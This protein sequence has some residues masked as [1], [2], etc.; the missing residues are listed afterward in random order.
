MPGHGLS[1]DVSDF[2]H[3]S[4]KRLEQIEPLTGTASPVDCL[5]SSGC[6]LNVTK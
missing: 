4:L 1:V 2:F 3:V 6:G 5:M